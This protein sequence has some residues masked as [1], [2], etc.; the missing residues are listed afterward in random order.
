MQ[1]F[2]TIATTDH[3]L[4]FMCWTEGNTMFFEEDPARAEKRYSIGEAS[5]LLDLILERGERWL[6]N[7]ND[8]EMK[9]HGNGDF[10]VVRVIPSF[11]IES[12]T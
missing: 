9:C 5:Q 8:E 7:K 12:I 1:E 6:L 10:C 2:Y 4:F 11:K 3:K